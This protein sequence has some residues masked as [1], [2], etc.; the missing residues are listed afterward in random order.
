MHLTRPKFA[1][2]IKDGTAIL[3]TGQYRGA[4]QL[5]RHG[6]GAWQHDALIQVK[7]VTIYRDAN[8][9]AILDTDVK[10]T[11]GLYGINIHAASL[12]Q[13]LD[14]IGE[15]SAGCQV[16]RRAI[17]LA[18]LV[19]LCRQQIRHIGVNSFTYTLLDESDF[20]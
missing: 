17:D 11:T 19:D 13:D 8:R 1:A 6:S 3:K 10:E 4:Y 12:W 5:G 16:L 9:D 18:K 14:R 7:P 15:Y 20:F 2:A